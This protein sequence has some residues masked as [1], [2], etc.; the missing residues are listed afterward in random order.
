M[1]GQYSFLTLV[2]KPE[3]ERLPQQVLVERVHFTFDDWFQRMVHAGE[4]TDARRV[5]YL[6]LC[7]DDEIKW[8]EWCD[9]VQETS[10]R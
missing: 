7:W 1:S 6:N 2:P 3:V 9:A 5:I 10:K 8:K 4:T